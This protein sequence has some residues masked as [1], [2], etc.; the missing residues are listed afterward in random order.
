MICIFF[1]SPLL[2]AGDKVSEEPRWARLAMWR[3]IARRYPEAFDESG[4][5][6]RG[7]HD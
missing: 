2:C 7:G 5:G 4:R 1:A 3:D 6:L